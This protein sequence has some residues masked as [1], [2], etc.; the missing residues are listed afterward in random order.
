[1]GINAKDKKVEYLQITPTSEAARKLGTPLKVDL[2]LESL[3]IRMT[4]DYS[5]ALLSVIL[6]R[7]SDFA[8]KLELP[9]K[10]PL[11]EN[12]IQ[13]FRPSH[14]RGEIAGSIELTNHFWFEFDKAG[15][16]SSFR[17]PDNYFFAEADH[18][19]FPSWT[20]EKMRSQSRFFGKTL[21]TT[22]EMIALARETIRKT[23]PQC[24]DAADR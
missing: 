17:S 2:Q 24:G 16:V 23:G 4:P 3:F 9:L 18:G 6:P 22:N 21:M 12:Q 10:F 1:V 14:I 13:Q 11:S 5:N 15:Y 19:L 20:P 8:N 7:I